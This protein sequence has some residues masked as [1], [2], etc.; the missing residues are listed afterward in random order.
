MHARFL[1]HVP[2]CYL[3]I[4]F[5]YSALSAAQLLLVDTAMVM[6]NLL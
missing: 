3:L 5:Q 6:S 2:A 1:P 4:T